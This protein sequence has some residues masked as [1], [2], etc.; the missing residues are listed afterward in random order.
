MASNQY[1]NKV[2]YG[3]TTLID[4]TSDTV[5]TSKLLSGY[6][7]HDKSGAAITG[8]CTFDADTSDA[9]AAQ[10]EILA[11]KTAYVNG[12]KVT[13]TMTNRGSVN[14]AIS[15]LTSTYTV[16]AGYHDGGG[17][18]YIDTTEQGKLI[19]QNIRTGITILG[20]TGSMSGTQ[21]VNAEAVT[22]VSGL[23]S[24]VVTP[25]T[26]YNYI[27]QVTV[28]AIPYSEADNSAGGKTVTIGSAA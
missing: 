19:A 2:I 7:A 25:G 16:P 15:S 4:L 26:G 5:T 3:G 13:G 28:Q 22:V 8:T 20:V 1:V 14:Q 11:S 12:S 21:D 17:K 18:V 10:G 6:T 27:S 9:T 23:T 24:T